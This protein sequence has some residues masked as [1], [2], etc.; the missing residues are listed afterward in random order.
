M[1]LPLRFPP[2]KLANQKLRE[3]KHAMKISE[4]VFL[5]TTFFK[6]S[7]LANVTTA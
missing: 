7:L 5:P 1:M 4:P 3:I 6:S 2:L